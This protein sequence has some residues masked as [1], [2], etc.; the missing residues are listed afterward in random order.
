MN[1]RQQ[2]KKAVIE[3]IHGKPYK[4][5]IVQKL[6][7][8]CKIPCDGSCE[9][10]DD[11]EYKVDSYDITIGRVI[12]ALNNKLG[13]WYTEMPGNTTRMASDVQEI[14]SDWK[15]TEPNGQECTDDDQSDETI[16][17]LLK[18]LK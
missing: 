5:C 7:T 11:W 2:F 4:K 13:I 17:K 6:H 15:L 18:L 8:C 3:A 16:D 9:E 1:T 10:N 12:Q 14:L